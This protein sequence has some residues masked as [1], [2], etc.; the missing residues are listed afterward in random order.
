[1][2]EFATSC[3]RRLFIFRPLD[4]TQLEA[5]LKQLPELLNQVENIRV[6]MIDSMTTFFWFDKHEGEE[7]RQRQKRTIAEIDRLLTN[8][9]L[10]LFTTKGVVFK[11]TESEVL[12]SIWN[13]LLQ[14]RCSVWREGFTDFRI[15]MTHPQDRNTIYKFTIGDSGPVFA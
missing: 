1:M 3:M 9:P 6:L 2:E 4:S 10:S 11:K 8:Y 12:P 15:K 13:N 5:N 7:G 14:Y